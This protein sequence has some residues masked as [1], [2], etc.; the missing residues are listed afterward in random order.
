[1]N[2]RKRR[3]LLL[4]MIRLR[5]RSTAY[6]RKWIVLGA[7]IGVIS[8]LGAA[9]FFMALDVAS[10]LFLGLAGYVPASPLGEGAKPI[11]DA[12]RP[13]DA[14]DRRRTRRPDR[15]HHRLPARSRG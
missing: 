1:M 12:A 15:G 7:V 10:Q 3:D 4:R 6:L 2:L 5:I 13:V 14:A 11:T 8:G 9:L